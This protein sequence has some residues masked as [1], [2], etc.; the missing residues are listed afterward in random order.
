MAGEW[1]EFANMVQLA[2]QDGLGES[3][4]YSRTGIATFAIRVIFNAAHEEI[5]L[6]DG[7]PVSTVRPR[8]AVHLQDLV[9]NGLAEPRQG[10]GL[11]VRSVDYE[12]VDIRDDGEGDAILILHRT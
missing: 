7:V 3:A 8:A 10:D 9:D 4:T 11:S 5:N 6:E 2:G 1:P 12:V